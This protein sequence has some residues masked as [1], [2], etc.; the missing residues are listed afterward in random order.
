MIDIT[1]L[2]AVPAYLKAHGLVDADD[3]PDLLPLSGGV[4]S[5]VVRVES[6]RPAF[7]I[8]QASPQLRVQE[9]WLAD[10]TRSRIEQD[11]LRYW[12]QLVPDM[13]PHFI[14]YDEQNFLF[15]MTAAPAS[16]V[17]WKTELLAGRL[18][19]SV[20]ERVAQALAV[21]QNAAANDADAW[22]RFS[23]QKVFDQLRL[24]PYLRFTATRHPDLKPVIDREID[25][26]INHRV[27]LVHGDYS[28]KN[29]LVDGSELFLLDFE[30]AHIGDPSFDLGFLT[31]HMLLKAVNHKSWA[32]GYLGMM[33]TIASTYLDAV[34]FSDPTSL[35][36]DSVR[37]LALLML[38]RV[39]GKS[40]VEYITHDSD[41]QLIRTLAY[42]ILKND[43]A[44]YDGVMELAW[45][46][47]SSTHQ[48]G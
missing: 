3:E 2:T 12:E 19:F 38:A 48:E 44:D 42:Q 6:R 9:E 7:V 37:S 46:A 25:R 11:C 32:L 30:V 14:Y 35:E 23:D 29:I 5:V 41:K 16:A 1:D 10:M 13:V 26:F 27:T 39:D 40:P 28:P 8:K 31:N 43:L 18:D 4:S 36:A 24:D 22:R 34:T 47:V 17:P 15:A 45:Q 33:R 21:V 20:A